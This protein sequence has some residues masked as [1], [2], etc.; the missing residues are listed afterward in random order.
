MSASSRR[1]L[2]RVAVVVAL[3]ALV[4]AGLGLAAFNT[5]LFLADL[6]DTPLGT[7]DEGEALRDRLQAAHGGLDRWRERAWIE[8]RATGTIPSRLARGTFG[9]DSETVELT[10]RF[11]PRDHTPTTMKLV[12]GDRTTEGAMPDLEPGHRMLAASIRHLFE[13]PFAMESADVIHGLPPVDGA[14]RVFMSWGTAAPQMQTDQYIL[15][16]DPKDRIFRFQATVRAVAPF[17]TADVAFDGA[18]EAEGL[19]L[20]RSA[21]VANAREGET[22]HAWEL[23]EMTPGPVVDGVR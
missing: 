22:I 11:D 2:R 10:L 8:L 14:P 4:A 12:H 18:I 16:L 23:L 1:I 19:M 9:C 13:L 17:V 7:V 21:R 15:W 6:V 3:L 20:P 5:P